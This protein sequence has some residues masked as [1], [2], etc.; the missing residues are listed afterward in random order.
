MRQN[1]D[2]DI[3]TAITEL[4]V[5]EAL[6]STLDDKGRP[7]ITERVF[8]LPPGSRIGPISAEER[9]ALRK[10]SLVAG[11]YEKTVDRES[12]YEVLK[13]RTEANMADADTAAGKAKEIAKEAGKEA[14]GAAA[15]EAGGGWLSGIGDMFGGGT[16]RTRASAGEQLIKSAA[17]SIGREVGR[18]VIRG[19]LGSILGGRRR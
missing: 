10:G 9:E 16:K 12:A 1:E 7:S 18:Q 3:A 2:L 14:A 8:V 11:V 4:A 13:G 17:S 15:E 5:G 19:V 6:V